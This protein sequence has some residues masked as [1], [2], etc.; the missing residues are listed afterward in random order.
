MQQTK[1][2]NNDEGPDSHVTAQED[3]IKRMFQKKCDCEAFRESRMP[4][5]QQN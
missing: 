5:K 2:K 3:T 4:I 1:E